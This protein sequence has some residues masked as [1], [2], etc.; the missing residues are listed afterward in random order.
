M[1][2]EVRS[3]SKESKFEGLDKQGQPTTVSSSRIENTFYALQSTFRSQ[4]MHYNR[5]YK[6][7]SCSVILGQL[8]SFRSY[9]GFSIIF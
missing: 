1:K 2:F 4:E 7:C 3:H 6:I 9:K 5:H 8:E